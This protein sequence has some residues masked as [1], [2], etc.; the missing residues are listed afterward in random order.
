[1]DAETK[2][3]IKGRHLNVEKLHEENKDNEIF[4]EIGEVIITGDTGSN[5][6]DI[7]LMMRS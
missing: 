4:E 3:K 7:Y 1:M 2:N 6:S 5:V